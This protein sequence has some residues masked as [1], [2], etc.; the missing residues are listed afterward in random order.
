VLIPAVRVFLATEPTD[1]RRGFDG[2]A[3]AVRDRLGSDPA[4]GAVFVFL[5]RNPRLVKLLFWDR[6]GYVLVAKRLERGRFSLPREVPADVRQ[7]EI[8]TPE[9]LLLLE[10]ISLAGSS[11]RAR[12]KPQTLTSF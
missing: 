2:L 1:L 3:A 6:S 11:R 5:G 12:W 9:L 10:G 8:E 4:S 7:L